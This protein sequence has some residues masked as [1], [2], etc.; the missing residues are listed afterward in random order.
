[1]KKSEFWKI[2]F[3]LILFDCVLAMFMLIFVNEKIVQ[4]PFYI[5]KVDVL[6][7]TLVVITALLFVKLIC[8]YKINAIV[9]KNEKYNLSSYNENLE[10][11]KSWAKQ[12]IIELAECYKKGDMNTFIKSV[13]EA[14]GSIEL[15][16]R[17]HTDCTYVNIIIAY[18]QRICNVNE[19]SLK[20]DLPY[21]IDKTNHNVGLTERTFNTIVGNIIDNAIDALNDSKQE[22][23]EISLAINIDES[24]VKYSIKNNGK[25]IKR[26]E[27]NKIF[28]M[29]YSSKGRNRGIGLFVV[30]KLVAQLDGILRVKS[31]DTET[32]FELSFDNK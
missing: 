12:K 31:S 23:K 27:L 17:R 26:K 13:D 14:I 3:G 19:I 15:D 5:D 10:L 16:S 25:K 9:D 28:K 24:N 6:Y 2:V 18:Y 29:H 30:M 22:K 7:I 21:K 8:F 32:C 11:E 4:M 20:L 1:M